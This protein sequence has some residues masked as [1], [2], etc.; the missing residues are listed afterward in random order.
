MT[1]ISEQDFYNKTKGLPLE[2]IV[3]AGFSFGCNLNEFDS[4]G[5][6]LNSYPMYV[7]AFPLR[8]GC[9]DGHCISKEGRYANLDSKTRNKECPKIAWGFSAY[10]FSQLCII[11]NG[12]VYNRKHHN[13]VINQDEDINYHIDETEAKNRYLNIL[14]ND[15]KKFHSG[16]KYRNVS[17]KRKRI[18]FLKQHIN[19]EKVFW[20]QTESVLKTYLCPPT[21]Q[22]ASKLLYDSIEII[23]NQY[24]KEIK[25]QKNDLKY[26]WIYQ[27]KDFV[28][29]HI[30][31]IISG[32]CAALLAYIYKDFAIMIYQYI[33]K[34]I[35]KD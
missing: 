19:D 29:K 4:F 17:E 5:I 26:N 3:F 1:F 7:R 20:K 2:D 34:L 11:V 22:K 32:F 31:K 35:E 12:E 9:Q 13:Y 14:W 21:S 24:L 25:E 8:G 33:C 10:L 27:T 28:K 15:Y 30:I 16:T 23:T 18:S 6:I